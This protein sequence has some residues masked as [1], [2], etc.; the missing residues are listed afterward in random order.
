MSA[1]AKDRILVIK[2]G[3]LGDFIQAFEAFRDIRAHHAAADIVLLTT[4]PFAGLAK[5]SP[6]F[7][8]VWTDG[9]PRWTQVSV[10]A[11]LAARLRRS[12]FT[13]IYDLQFNRRTTIM[14]RVV[15]GR[16]GPPWL[17]KTPGCAFPEP[18]YPAQTDNVGR[19]RAHLQSAGTPS[20][21]PLDLSWLSA[22]VADIRPSGRFVLLAPGCSAHRPRKRW[23]PENYAALGM[24]LASRH[25]SVALVGTKVDQDAID[26]IRA[27]LP[28]ALDLAG[29]TDFFKLAS[30]ARVADAFV[31]ND[32]GPTFLA[33]K[34]G[35]PTLTLMSVE[36][37]ELRMAPRGAAARW[38]KR[39]NLADLSVEE[40]EA[41]LNLP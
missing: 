41:A 30:L 38:I 6:W 3:S 12:D 29:R 24:K 26:V 21:G 17:G 19:L 31:G 36:T 15:G 40:V 11:R 7:D 39:D 27:K 5:G 35:A 9:R 37:D 1:Q 13:R 16:R 33:A 4:P 8:E 23:P 28:Q 34:V 32:T 14:Y 2:L 18:T 10:W 25:Y 22:D 20:A